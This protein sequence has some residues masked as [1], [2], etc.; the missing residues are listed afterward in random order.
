MNHSYTLMDFCK[1]VLKHI[2]TII[3]FALAFGILLGGY[4]KLKQTTTYSAHRNIV[5]S[6]NVDKVNAKDKNSRVLADMQ[7]M[8]TY[9]KVADDQ[10]IYNKAQKIL[11]NKYHLKMDTQ[12]IKSAVK[13]ESEPQTVIMS[14]TASGKKEGKVVKIANAIS[15]A[16]KEELPA[17]INNTG[18]IKL[19]S[20]AIKSDLKSTTGPSAKK[21]AVLGVAAGLFVGL[22]VVF[23]RYTVIDSKESQNK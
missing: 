9:T 3:I 15:L 8:T 14:V 5:V 6:H 21:Y 18:T 12:M 20:P 7:M 13:M 2:L 17:L 23:G 1:L 4:A 16:I 10:A 11:K 22:I 19:L